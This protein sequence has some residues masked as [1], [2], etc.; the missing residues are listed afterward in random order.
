MPAG[1]VV[2]FHQDDMWHNKLEGHDHVLG[3][4]ITKV[5][6]VLEGRDLAKANHV[7]HVVTKPDG[8]ISERIAYGDRQETVTA[9]VGT[10]ES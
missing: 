2:T 6:A 3:S 5:Q 9:G 8:T 4:Y 1:D 7:S 10:P